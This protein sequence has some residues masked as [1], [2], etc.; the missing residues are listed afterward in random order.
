MPLP[1]KIYRSEVDS[2]RF[3]NDLFF[4]LKAVSLYIPPLRERREDINPLIEYF[5][6]N[7]AEQNNITTPIITD[8]AYDLL[9][10]YYWPGNIRELKNVIET[11]AAL[12]TTG[13]LGIVCSQI[14]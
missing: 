10:N 14:Y 1:I 4:R 6:N 13:K 12:D 9:N 3:R 2:K 5:L 8:D 11:A 7:Y